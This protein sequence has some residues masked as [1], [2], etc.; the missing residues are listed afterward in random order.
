[1]SL[2]WQI[3]IELLGSTVFVVLVL[4]AVR[5]RQRQAVLWPPAPADSGVRVGAPKAYD[6]RSLSLMLEQ[7]QDQ[8]RN[9]Q[10]IDAK[11]L[12]AT[13]GTQQGEIRAE[14]GGS[15]ELGPAQA[16]PP[17]RSASSVSAPPEA[18][19]GKAVSATSAPA[20]A[21]APA[22]KATT[23]V[24]PEFASG[25]KWSERAADL[26]GDQVNLSYQI[27]NLRLLLERAISDRLLDDGHTRIQAVV[28]V[29]VSI[30]PPPF[31]VD[32][33]ATVEVRFTCAAGA[34]SVV[35]LF[36]QQETYNTWG[37]DRRQAG[38]GVT[39]TAYG[40]SIG[41]KGRGAKDQ[42][43]LLRQADVVALER[44]STG[45]AVVVAWQ[46]RP[47]L[48]QKTVTP[49][50]RQMLAVLALRNA[51]RNQ[52]DATVEVSVRTRWNRWRAS[53]QS[54]G[55]GPGWRAAL[56]DRPTG[57]DWQDNGSVRIPTT[58]SVEVRLAPRIDTIS[59]FRVG[60][61][62]AGVVVSGANFFPG[63]TVV[64]GDTTLDSP[65]NGLTIKSERSLQ[66]VVP[67]SALLGDALLNGRYGRSLRLVQ[68]PP[69]PLRPV[70]IT[71]VSLKPEPGNQAYTVEMEFESRDQSPIHWGAFSKLVDPILTI[72]GRVVSNYLVFHHDDTTGTVSAAIRVTADFFPSKSVFITIHWPFFG[73]DWL[74]NY[75]TYDPSITVSANR[76]TS[77]TTASLVLSGAEFNEQTK[78]FLDRT[79]SIEPAGPLQRL[80]PDLLRLDVDAGILA[81]YDVCFLRG[82]DLPSLAVRIPSTTSTSVASI[83]TTTKPPALIMKTGGAID[84]KG[85]AL[86][87]VTE[88]KL[89]A[90]ALPFTTYGAGTGITVVVAGSLVTTP[91][92]VDVQL[93]TRD[94]VTLSAPLLITE[95]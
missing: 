1:M 49:G 14:L 87:T 91:G 88:A 17:V 82:P 89:G 47:A 95:Q 65:R 84:Y 42:A 71:S 44:P 72:N 55:D 2:W 30:E 63:T 43:H 50:L 13:L 12:L 34:P 70:W 37:V 51:D 26:L 54:A 90:T 15:L 6:N 7:L 25:L 74:L 4:V 68:P 28:G 22:G 39:A 76:F 64:M 59:W 10:S 20:A 80:A 86:E 58:E 8:L 62:T 32:S 40:M 21:S 24:A 56:T 67:M 48:G 53:S 18:S 75:Q 69:A 41:A 11:A 38:V 79:Y 60:T 16:A 5:V 83:D 19:A 85:T 45:N 31:A 52:D 9:V 78:L 33:A 29:P 61:A 57:Q 27:F 92:K 36:P 93:T 46:F 35:A 77:G 81:R 73:D 94:R 66:I 23:G 3:L